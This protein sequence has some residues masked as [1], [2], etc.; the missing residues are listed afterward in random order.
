MKFAAFLAAFALGSSCCEAYN[1]SLKQSVVSRRDFGLTSSA[2]A[3][4]AL[5]GATQNS[6]AFEGSGSSAYTG[7]SPTSKA[8]LQKSYRARI[9][10]DVRDFNALGAAIRAGQTEGAA[11]TN[12][13]IPY[14]RREPDSVGRTYAALADLVG[15]AEGGGCGYL[16][17]ASLAKPGKPPETVPAVKKYN[18]LAKTFEPIK[19]AGKKGDVAKAE[20]AW[21]KSAIA[22]SE[23]LSVVDMPPSMTDDLYK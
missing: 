14:A 11:W 23:Y 9:A 4:A 5:L 13:F 18:A 10:A 7:R 17:A 16:F 20:A 3:A 12:F 1:V 22:F 8:D 6:N 19:A 21:E 2:T 15:N